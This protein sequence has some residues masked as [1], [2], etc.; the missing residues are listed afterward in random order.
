MKITIKKPGL[1]STIQ[2]LGRLNYLSQ[3]VPVSG[4]MDSLSAQIANIALGNPGNSAV[5]EFTQSGASLSMDSDIL[6]AFSGD[7]AWLSTSGN[8]LPSDKP[9]F[10]PAGT[11]LYLAHNNI[12]SRSYL[13]VAGGWDVPV[14]LGSRSTYITAN[15]GGLAGR[16]LVENDEICGTNELSAT[17]EAIWNNLKGDAIKYPAWSI[18]RSMFLPE[19]RKTIRVLPG[20]EFGWF[21][22]DSKADLFL[23][24]YTV[25]LNSNRMGYNLQAA[26]MK[27][28]IEGEL[29]STAVT[30]GT[31]QVANNGE[32]IMLMADCQTIGGYPRVAQVAAVDMPLCAQLKPGDTIN[33][34][35]ISWKQAEKLYFQHQHDLH[36]LALTITQKYT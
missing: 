31:I 21:D 2:D 17:T 11:E 33:F 5:I 9:V 13:A 12:G 34:K 26:Q 18:G 8:R 19:D 29:L 16:C 35:E 32:L 22:E 27:R 1:L 36:K 30:P 14:V 23:Q 4:A 6:L 7:G 25:G 15:I 20:R 3:A 28:A 24:S 10:I